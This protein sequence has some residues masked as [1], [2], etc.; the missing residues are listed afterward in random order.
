MITSPALSWS[1][2]EEF[3]TGGE[4]TID[5][6]RCETPNVVLLLDRSG[7]ML[8]DMKWEQ[9]TTA[10]ETTIAPYF[11]TL[12]FGLLPFPTDGSCGVMEEGLAIEVGETGSADLDA[13]FNESLP[14]D[15]ALTP[16]VEVINAGKRA[17]EAVHQDDRRGFLILLTDGIETCAPEAIEDT[18][19]VEA[20]RLAADVGYQTY[21]IGFGTRVRR[22]VLREMAMVGGTGMER[23]VSDQ[24]TLEETFNSIIESATTE[25]CDLL[26]ND[27]DGR[28]DEGADCAPP[29]YPEAGGDCPCVNN[30]DC[31]RGEACVDALCEPIPCDVACDQGY[32]CRAEECIPLSTLPSGGGSDSTSGGGTMTQP[33]PMFAGTTG[34]GGGPSLPV[35]GGS[36]AASA[37]AEPAV[38]SGGGCRSSSTRRLTSVVLITFLMALFMTLRLR[39]RT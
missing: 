4:P 39:A 11:E 18:A 23:L 27:C 21:V 17:L 6:S 26:D 20:V 29:C 2:S 14:V 5:D 12:R 16:I 36:T 10:I 7:S 35:T 3:E 34:E 24:A 32:I 1:Q 33:Q 9:A 15:T 13:I 28:I 37:S 19:P 8:D 22:A 25:I 30:R 31:N 38:E